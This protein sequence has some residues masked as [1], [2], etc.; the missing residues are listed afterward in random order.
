MVHVTATRIVDGQHAVIVSNFEGFL[1]VLL[2][3]QHVQHVRSNVASTGNVQRHES[4][5]SPVMDR[6]RVGFHN[7]LDGLHGRIHGT[8]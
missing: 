1:A 8:R 6:R 2:Q 7:G 3:Q 4:G 5:V